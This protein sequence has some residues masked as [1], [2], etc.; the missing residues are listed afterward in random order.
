M[1]KSDETANSK[2][3]VSLDL[4]V[5]FFQRLEALE[6]TTHESKSGVIRQALQLYEYIVQRTVE[7]Y[8][9]KAVGPNGKEE[10]LVFFGPYIPTLKKLPSVEEEILV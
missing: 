2:V 10:N 1:A 6:E 5:P 4:S 7:G 9:F 3:R 8:S